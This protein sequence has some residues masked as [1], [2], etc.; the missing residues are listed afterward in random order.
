MRV[1]ISSL[2]SELSILGS[3][4][5]SNLGCVRDNVAWVSSVGF[6]VEPPFYFVLSE[7]GFISGGRFLR[8]WII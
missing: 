3:D 7:S 5:G 6:G 2:G 1:G 4:V 8:L